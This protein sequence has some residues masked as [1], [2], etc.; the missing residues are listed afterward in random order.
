MPMVEQTLSQKLPDD[1]NER[2]I[3]LLEAVKSND[4]ENVARML[5]LDRQ[6]LNARGESNATALNLAAHHGLVDL[7]KLLLASGADA[8]EAAHWAHHGKPSRHAAL[9]EILRKHVWEHDERLKQLNSIYA[10]TEAQG[11]GW[12]TSE[13]IVR[14]I[15]A[16]TY[17][18]LSSGKP[19]GVK[20]IQPHQDRFM[21]L[22]DALRRGQPIES[23]SPNMFF[24]HQV[25][26]EPPQ[27]IFDNGFAVAPET[28]LPD[29]ELM[30]KNA[31]A[32]Q[33][34]SVLLTAGY[35]QIGKAWESLKRQ[36]A[37]RGLDVDWNDAREVYPYMESFDSPQNRTE[38]QVRIQS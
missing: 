16:T 22:V 36:I 19:I 33:L 20:E 34:A 29:G 7:V 1:F 26:T 2:L 27:W 4:T 24:Y 28:K 31:P 14:E 11:E 32:M 17:L 38:I 10:K 25:S 30:L 12:R 18:I 23:L 8:T 21:R 5:K 3:A 6:L 13:L 9:V 35:P 15:P 37:A